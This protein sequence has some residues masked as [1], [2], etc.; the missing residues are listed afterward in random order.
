MEF[1]VTRSEKFKI[2]L[3]LFIFV[4]I[5]TEVQFQYKR[6]F[7]TLFGEGL[8]LTGFNKAPV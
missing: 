3:K 4:L 6:T 8:F 2:V 7:S 5:S 1:L